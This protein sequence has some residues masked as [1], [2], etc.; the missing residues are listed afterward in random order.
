MTGLTYCSVEEAQSFPYIV[1]GSSLAS[2]GPREQAHLE[3]QGMFLSV[4][5]MDFASVLTK[6][7]L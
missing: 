1:I 3:V 2:I 5:L 6:W 7:G 4:E